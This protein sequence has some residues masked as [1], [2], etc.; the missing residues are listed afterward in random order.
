MQFYPGSGVF[1]S[2]LHV[3]KKTLNSNNEDKNL[4]HLEY[5][6]SGVA[7]FL[8]CLESVM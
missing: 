3:K 1:N 2:V 7:F 6:Y 5:F 4:N 8:C